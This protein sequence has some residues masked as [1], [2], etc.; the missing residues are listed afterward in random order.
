[1]N[2]HDDSPLAVLDREFLTSLERKVPGPEY[3][4]VVAPLLPPEEWTIHPQGVWT[5]VIPH[6]WSALQQGWKLHVSATPGNGAEVL[7]RVATVVKEDPAAFKF[8]SDLR[9]L[10]LILTKNWSREGGGKFIT[11]YPADDEQFGRLGRAL[12]EATAGLEGPYIL[13]DS[14][15]PGS[16]IVFYRY[17]EHRSNETVDLAGNRIHGLVSPSGETVADG[18]TGWYALP[19]WVEDPYGAQPIDVLAAR[20][21]GQ[22]AKKVVMQDRYEIHGAIK[23]SN[24]GGVYYGRDLQNDRPVVIRERRPHTGWVD[25]TTDAVA[26]LH[27]EAH[28]LRQMDGSGW[29]PSFVDE[30]Q[31]WEH[32][33]LVMEQVRGMTLRDFASSRYH[34]RRGLPSPR[35]VFETFRH[36]ILELVRGIEAFHRHGVIVRDLTVGN[37]LV[38]PDRTVCFIDLEY[39]WERGGSQAYAPG[40]A[41]PGF[42]S[43]A[44]EAGEPPTEADDYWS[45]GAVVVEMCSFM[46]GGLRLNPRGVLATASAMIDERGLPRELL[47][48]AQ[49]LLQP[50]PAARWGAAEVRRALGEVRGSTIPWVS[51]EPGR[52]V[53]EADAPRRADALYGRLAETCEGVCGFFE[54]GADPAYDDCLWPVPSAV[55]RTNPVS[56]QHGACGPIE[57][58]RRVRGGCP[59]AWLDWVERQAG[60]ERCPPGL[61]SGLAGVALTL[62]SCGRAGS[63]LRL[64][65]V[66]AHHPLLTSSDDLYHGAAGVALV[67]A[68]LASALDDGEA[69]ETA[70]RIGEGIAL[71]AIR[72]ARGLAWRTGNEA[73]RSGLAH[74]GSGIALFHTCLGALTGDERNWELARKALEFEFAQG[75]RL[76]GHLSWPERVG[77]GRRYWSPHVAFGTA[78]VLSA[79]LRLYA[80]TADGEL[81]AWCERCAET[82]THRWTNKLW[83]D[84]GLAGWGETLLD[85]HAVTGEGR[86]LAHAARIAEVLLHNQVRTRFGVAFP[87]E[88]L[89]RVTSDFGMGTSGVA[90]FLHRM[91]HGGNRAFFPDHLLPGW[92]APASAAPAAQRVPGTGAAVRQV[93]GEARTQRQVS[94]AGR[95]RRKVAVGVRAG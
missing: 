76:S 17:G 6:G 51:P 9:I 71:R 95:A 81:L 15:V 5:H 8:A 45:L 54:A 23:Y 74:G 62:A 40:I 94:A 19:D 79:A 26:L 90:L 92:P 11:L 3:H 59:E 77:R 48:V 35:R 37:V 93:P 55:Y 34:K 69:R 64:L 28:V 68:A 39:A 31:L 41:T 83:Q 73:I 53:T 66:A 18:R 87:G 21:P 57:Y 43:P 20:Q 67:A 24:V 80:C 22:E 4:A 52:E 91:L 13:S 46:A 7:A 32:H 84:M 70:I 2:H 44:Q 16:R 29:T 27:Q 82:L 47:A 50:D 56:I 75:R 10:H 30:F 14:R 12:A 86:Y 89:S 36:L 65:R 61:H 25:A 1:M 60:P 63:A 38:R 78:G 49:D 33:F 85:L 88:G 72:L 42:A 58:V